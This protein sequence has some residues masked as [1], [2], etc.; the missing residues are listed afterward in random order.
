[1]ND[2]VF[3]MTKISRKNRLKGFL[4]WKY[5]SLRNWIHFKFFHKT[6][7]ICCENCGEKYEAFSLDEH[8]SHGMDTSLDWS[9]GLLICHYGSKY[10]LNLFRILDRDHYPVQKN[11]QPMENVC[12]NCIE[13]L[14]LEGVLSDGE[15]YMFSNF[16]DKEKV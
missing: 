6:E 8:Q 15:E 11:G 3:K 4:G 7:Y 9:N 14:V 16:K 1:M 13:R 12:D 2:D 10:D 5:I